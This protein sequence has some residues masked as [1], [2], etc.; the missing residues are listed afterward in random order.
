MLLQRQFYISKKLNKDTEKN[1]FM[2][3]KPLTY[4]Y[5]LSG[6]FCPRPYGYTVQ[7]NSY[8]L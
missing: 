8:K 4:K 5:F 3:Q 1:I 2:K 7:K 6:G